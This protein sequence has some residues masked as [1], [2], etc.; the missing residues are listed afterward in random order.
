MNALTWFEIPST[1]FDRALNF[2]NTVLGQ[3]LELTENNGKPYGIFPYEQG[4]GVGGAVVFDDQYKPS[5]DSFIIY[6][7]AHSESGLD[8][9]LERVPKAGG[10]VLMPKMHI[11]AAGFVALILDSEGNRVGLNAPNSN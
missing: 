4:K 1:D 10:K 8:A 3:S 2:Y 5:A 7:N 6:L 11:E 9:I